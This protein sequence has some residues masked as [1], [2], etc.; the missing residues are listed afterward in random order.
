MLHASAYPIHRNPFPI[1]LE[2]SVLSSS[3]FHPN[4]K[5]KRSQRKTNQYRLYGA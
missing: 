5:N 2:L 4:D 3:T 1:T